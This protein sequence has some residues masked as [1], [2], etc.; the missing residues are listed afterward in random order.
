MTGRLSSIEALQHLLF[1]QASKQGF[2][3]WRECPG[4]G[5]GSAEA[6]GLTQA[7]SCS[8]PLPLSAL[9]PFVTTGWFDSWAFSVLTVELGD[10]AQAL[11][12]LHYRRLTTACTFC[13]D[14]VVLLPSLPPQTPCLVTVCRVSIDWQTH[15][16]VL[17]PSL[18]A[19][20]VGRIPEVQFKCHQLPL[21]K[22]GV[23]ARRKLKPSPLQ[24]ALLRTS[25][26]LLQIRHDVWP[27]RGKEITVIWERGVLRAPPVFQRVGGRAAKILRSAT[28]NASNHSSLQCRSGSQQLLVS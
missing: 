12:G 6:A 1:H 11:C 21:I 16:C 24:E 17:A 3:S 19:A 14:E 25:G 10:S 4:S 9:L 7:L 23:P 28:G 20:K 8:S 15:V 22:S 18:V 26:I 13:L 27:L 5:R 2:G